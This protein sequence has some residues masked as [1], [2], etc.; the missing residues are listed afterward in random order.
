LNEFELIQR[1]FRQI[2]KLRTDVVVGVGD[3]AAVCKVPEN[4]ELVVTTDLLVAGVHFPEDTPA[5]AIGHKALAVNLSDLAAMGAEPAWFTLTLSLP[6]SNQSWL[7]DF[8]LG[9]SDLANASEVA[10]IGGDTTRGAL[11]IGIQACGFVPT[12]SA[13]LR[14]TAR[15]GDHIFV[16]GHLG[17]AATG[18]L[19]ETGKLELSA[20]AQKYFSQCLR[21]PI[22]RS[23]E[24]LA[25]NGVA[26]AMIDVSDGLAADLG[27]ILEASGVGASI[28]Q[29]RLPISA[30]YKKLVGQVGTDAV[31]SG[32]D[33]YELCFTVPSAR[34]DNLQ[35]LAADWDCGVTE[36]G[37]IE[38]AA[39]LRVI[40]EQGGLVDVVRPGYQH[41]SDQ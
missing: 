17:D 37:R 16:T 22:P 7:Q 18:L 3:D 26:S 5:H 12:G 6:E 30:H 2:G 36:I 25:L 19:G 38:S 33:D 32:G 1:Y 28:Q 23:Q 8:S 41:F 14:S 20:E 11:T 39:G 24:G 35:K 27:H 10:L 29:S 40:D 15:I 31:L 4:H 9:L 21:Y 13:V 34:I